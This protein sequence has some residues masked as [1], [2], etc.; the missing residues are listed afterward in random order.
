MQNIPIDGLMVFSTPTPG[1]Q[2][3]F[4]GMYLFE[5]FTR[6]NRFKLI[7]N[8]IITCLTKRRYKTLLINNIL[9]RKLIK[10]IV[11]LILVFIRKLARRYACGTHGPSDLSK[12]QKNQRLREEKIFIL[13]YV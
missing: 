5:S 3:I 4:I 12:K 8:R 1:Y 2:Q 7:C 9:V 6:V 13:L 11:C 10:L